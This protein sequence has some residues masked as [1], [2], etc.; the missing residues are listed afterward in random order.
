MRKM[1]INI[2]CVN[3]IGFSNAG[4][5]TAL[6]EFV[7]SIDKCAIW[8]SNSVAIS[9]KYKIAVILE[10]DTVS[11]VKRHFNLLKKY[12]IN[13]IVCTSHTGE[14]LE[15]IYSEL[16]KLNFAKNNC[17]AKNKTLLVFKERD[18]KYCNESSSCKKDNPE[19]CK[20]HNNTFVEK[21]LDL[22]GF[23]FGIDFNYE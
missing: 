7:L 15:Q 4:K 8:L 9:D 12:E 16:V 3:I 14:T 1:N 22:A 5:T 13:F 11:I 19:K 20:R 10:G 21:M 18:C 6:R 17:D 23:C 2:K